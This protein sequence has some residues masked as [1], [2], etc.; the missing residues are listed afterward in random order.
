MVA[1]MT[2]VL[3]PGVF[4]FC[5]MLHN[6]DSQAAVRLSKGSFAEDEG[7]SLILPKA[8]ADRLGLTYDT[9]MRQITLMVFSSMT[10]VG[11]TAA[12]TTELARQKIPANV[13]AATQHDHVFVPTKR[14]NEAMELLRDLQARA[15]DGD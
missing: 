7:M 5:S 6:D 13:V 9:E 12:V 10:G 2:P 3:Q 1:S 11:L 8:E 15:R 14:A 4:V